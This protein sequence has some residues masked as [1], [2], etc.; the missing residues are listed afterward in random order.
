MGV[1]NGPKC[2]FDTDLGTKILRDTLTEQRVLVQDHDRV[3]CLTAHR[4]PL[5]GGT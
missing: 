4:L 3:Q 2:R 1:I 5:S